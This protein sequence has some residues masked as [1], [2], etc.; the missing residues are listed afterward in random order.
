HICDVDNHARVV[1]RG[2]A[3]TTALVSL[4]AA[5]YA[6]GAYA[7]AY[8]QSP[9][10]MGQFRPAIVIPSVFAVLF[11]PWVG[12]VGAALGTLVAD[13]IKHGTLYLPSLIAAVPSN[14]AAF[15]LL[16]K[17]LEGRFRWPRFITAS[18]LCLLLG[19]ALCAVLYT[20]YKAA[21]G[22]LPVQMIPGL[23]V[24]LTT[25]WFS[26]MI[27][28][29]LLAVPPIL[30]GLVK[31]LPHLTPPDVRKEC[32]EGVTPKRE[33]VLALLLASIP[34]LVVAVSVAVSEGVADFFVGALPARVQGLVRSLIVVMFAAT[35]VG[36]LGAS[37]FVASGRK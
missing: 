25:W 36:L 20:S 27:P 17:L 32:T 19:N 18:L 16:G 6:C 13:S 23:S 24:G 26:T 31:A 28:F 3:F 14:F 30:R 22:A 15:F 4:N 10:G 33:L 9:W 7:T 37:V 5:L 11:G 8:I 2:V 12:G 1:K 34:A 35:G 21:I 29:Q